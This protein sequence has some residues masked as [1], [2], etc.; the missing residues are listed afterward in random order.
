MEF[1]TKKLVASVLWVA[2]Q[3]VSCVH[4]N[5]IKDLVQR[6]NL[7]NFAAGFLRKNLMDAN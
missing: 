3:I 6:R 2:L 7:K 1:H 4:Q 5:L